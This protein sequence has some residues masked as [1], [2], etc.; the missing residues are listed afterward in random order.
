MLQIISLYWN[1]FVLF[2]TVSVCAI[3]WKL[4]WCF[5]FFPKHFYYVWIGPTLP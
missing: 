2:Y 5:V 4:E 3:G 1:V